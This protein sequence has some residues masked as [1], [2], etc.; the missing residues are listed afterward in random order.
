MVGQSIDYSWEQLWNELEF[1]TNYMLRGKAVRITDDRISA[2]RFHSQAGFLKA[3]GVGLTFRPQGDI[4]VL[5]E[6]QK[7]ITALLTDIRSDETE[8]DSLIKARL[9]QEAFRTAALKKWNNECAVTGCKTMDALRASHIKPWRS[10]S[11]SERLDGANGIILV[12]NLDTLFDRHLITFDKAGRLK[13]SNAVRVKDRHVLSHN[14]SGLRKAFDTHHEF[15]MEHHR[16]E[17][18]A[19]EERLTE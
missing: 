16:A 9:G 4:S 19:L 15:Y 18:R 12:A 1:K 11:P 2:S 6:L 13:W 5:D 17:F 8:R 7:D 14:C 3:L 10:C